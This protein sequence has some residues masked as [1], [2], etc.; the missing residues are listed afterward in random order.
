[1]Q[2]NQDK[3]DAIN[4]KLLELIDTQLADARPSWTLPR[5]RS[6]QAR[7]E[8]EKQLKNFRHW[9]TYGHG[10]M[11][12]EVGFRMDGA[13]QA[14]ALL[15]SVNQ[16]I[17]VVNE[18]EIQQALIDVRDGLQQVVDKFNET[19]MRD[20]DSLIEIVAELRDITDKLTTALQKLQERL[21]AETD[22]AGTT[23]GDL[24]DEL[25]LQQ[26]LKHL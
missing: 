2:L 26:S 15:E 1:M 4:A 13:K 20:I 17:A 6:P 22:T 10:Q 25:Q 23:A 12:T 7:K 3:I 5:P 19:G 9:S 21:N 18:P 24:A 11:S 8:Y 14:Q 16:L